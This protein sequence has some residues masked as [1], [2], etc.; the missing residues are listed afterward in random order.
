MIPLS[1]WAGM[2]TVAGEHILRPASHPLTLVWVGASPPFPRR[3]A[4]RSRAGS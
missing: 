4:P 2:G 3:A 1:G